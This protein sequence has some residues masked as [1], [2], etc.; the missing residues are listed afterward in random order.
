[1]VISLLTRGRSATPVPQLSTGAG[2]FVVMMTVLLKALVM[3]L[4]LSVGQFE[5]ITI[6]IMLILI[7]IIIIIIII[8]IIMI[9][10]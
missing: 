1:M 5:I 2:T 6:I 10:I 7:I 4:A 3:E 8:M 9:I